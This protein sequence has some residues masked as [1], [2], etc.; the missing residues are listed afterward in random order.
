MKVIRPLVQLLGTILISLSISSTA[1]KTI[2]LLIFWTAAF[3]PLKASELIQF[4]IVNFIFVISN[5]GALKNGVFEFAQ[6]D[7]LLMPYNELFMWGFYCFFVQRALRL[8]DTSEGH[9]KPAIIYA[10][11]F[12]VSFS[13]IRDEV[14]L[15]SALAALLLSAAVIFRSKQDWLSVALFTCVGILIESTGLWKGFWRYPH[16]RYFELPLWGP[17]M[18]AN[19][20]MIVSRLAPGLQNRMKNHRQIPASMQVK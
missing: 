7:I 17:L 18:W 16:A 19:I 4:V 11:L 9:L 13:V 8:Q 2:A 6:K 14:I 15:A 1:L 20:G 3:W 12:A 10:V 5:Y